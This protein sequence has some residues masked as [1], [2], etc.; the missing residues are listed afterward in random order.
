VH[1][2]NFEST[3]KAAGQGDRRSLSDVYAHYN[4][5]LVRYLR[6][7]APGFGEDLAQEAWLE[8]AAQLRGFD[9]GER[10]F[11]LL[12]L[13]EAR[14]QA[15]EFKRRSGREPVRPV[16]PRSLD[17]LRAAPVGD[18]TVADAALA[19]LLEGLRPLQAEILLL[20]VVGGLSADE[21][22]ALLGKSAN[23]IRV[24]QHRVLRHLARRLKPDRVPE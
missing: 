22:G 2:P 4:P 7:Q 9:G 17:E 11:R 8:V 18:A 20:R 15:A 14:H 10:E 12:L 21:V 3:L 16:P 5:L 24:T 6:A 13:A 1:E 23:M 19:E